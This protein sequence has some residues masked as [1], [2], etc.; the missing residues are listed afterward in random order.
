MLLWG[1]VGFIKSYFMNKVIILQGLPGSGKSTWAKQFCMETPNSLI[2][3]KDSLRKMLNCG[4]WT[5]E[6]EKIVKSI[7]MSALELILDRCDNTT[8]VVDDTNLRLKTVNNLMQICREH[9]ADVAL[10]DFFHVPLKDCIERDSKREHPVGS[11][12][13]IRM[14][15]DLN[16]FK[17]YVKGL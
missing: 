11:S 4:E 2:L 17:Q 12:A 10:K 5:A 3:N 6:Y 9:N 15:E 1:H 13:I 8:V 7:E 14:N 16:T